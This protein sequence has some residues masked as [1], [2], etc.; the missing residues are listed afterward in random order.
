MPLGG[1]ELLLLLAGTGA[2]YTMFEAVKA[3]LRAAKRTPRVKM[4][5]PPA[6]LG[7][8]TPLGAPPATTAALLEESRRVAGD[9]RALLGD[10]YGEPL[11]LEHPW[12]PMS[13]RLADASLAHLHGPMEPP[14]LLDD[15]GSAANMPRLN[16]TRVQLTCPVATAP[17]G[18]TR[19]SSAP[20]LRHYSISSD[21]SAAPLSSA[22][23]SEAK[24]PRSPKSP[25]D[26]DTARQRRPAALPKPSL[27]AEPEAAME[28]PSEERPA[29]PSKLAMDAA[30]AP[31]EMVR[32]KS[33]G[34]RDP[35]RLLDKAAYSEGA[36]LLDVPHEQLQG[37]LSELRAAELRAVRAEEEVR[38]SRDLIREM[39]SEVSLLQESLAERLGM[40]NNSRQKEHILEADLA[41]LVAQ[42]NLA[43]E[44]LNSMQELTEEHQAAAARAEAELAASGAAAKARESKLIKQAKRY[45]SA[46]KDAEGK[47][48]TQVARV[49][50]L[51]A[52]LAG[53]M[54]MQEVMLSGMRPSTT[55]VPS[56]PQGALPRAR[57]EA[58]LVELREAH[59]AAEAE[60]AELHAR[61]ST[62]SKQAKKYRHAAKEAEAALAAQRQA[63]SELHGAAAGADAAVSAQ[64]GA[65][66][67]LQAEVLAKEGRIGDL[68]EE[69]AGLR[70]LVEAGNGRGDQLGEL[71]AELE[72]LRATRDAQ[73][74]ELA[75][76]QAEMANSTAWLER[77]AA[78]LSRANARMAELT[79]E[80]AALEA[81]LHELEGQRG[82]LGELAGALA[83][84]ETMRVELE[85]LRAAAARPRSPRGAAASAG[86]D[87]EGVARRTAG[88][89]GEVEAQLTARVAG[90][91]RTTGQLA[92]AS[93]RAAMLDVERG[94]LEAEVAELR[95]RLAEL[96]NREGR[97]AAMTAQLE[98][99]AAEGGEEVDD[100][101]AAEAL[102]AELDELSVARAA[103]SAEASDARKDL[104]NALA[105]LDKTRGLLGAANGRVAALTEEKIGLE[106]S[107]SRLQSREAELRRARLPTW[108]PTAPSETTATPEPAI[109]EAEAE[110]VAGMVELEGQRGQLSERQFE[111]LQLARLQRTSTGR[112]MVKAKI[113][114]LEEA[115]ELGGLRL[116]VSPSPSPSPSPSA[117]RHQAAARAVA[118]ELA[119]QR[120]RASIS[121][122]P[123]AA[124]AAPSPR[125][126]LPGGMQH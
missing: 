17:P 88:E 5:L 37:L 46:A 86:D 26:L 77:T 23:A 106:A 92:T 117:R 29:K 42:A 82:Q 10:R 27:K 14:L 2:A 38:A 116:S 65:L 75:E 99:L 58:E 94:A 18:P 120:R 28:P 76:L 126:S 69:L 103:S 40:L 33:P 97:L 118:S 59:Q 39:S 20:P 19:G 53:L 91:E 70:R 83:A 32:A 7:G 8:G 50:E 121:A 51:E 122:S 3:G 124:E 90:L 45:R 11:A 112:A 35:Y 108:R 24:A 87:E 55:G 107:V 52:T 125:R 95:G 4:A 109:E 68:E 13:L 16:V 72:E 22:A 80:K 93:A 96:A 74:A 119:Q 1:A 56:S 60:L 57:S 25:E 44:A 9:L 21:G 114:E 61:L 85:S 89:L 12:E 43:C 30:A 123:A 41:Q 115:G 110:V 79:T 64:A 34:E 84:M 63:V 111:L 71:Q 113:A 48:A 6:A 102:A 105:W 67:A 47:L 31:Q 49:S 100:G 15:S 54:A 66:Q 101:A 98:V 104:S 81:A 73:A 78:Q 62:V 36:G